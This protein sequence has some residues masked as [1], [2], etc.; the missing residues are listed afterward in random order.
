MKFDPAELAELLS[1]GEIRVP[2]DRD[3]QFEL[4]VQT[5]VASL[6]VE[7]AGDAVDA[8]VR[9]QLHNIQR[10]VRGLGVALG[11]DDRALVLEAV[12]CFSLEVEA[13]EAEGRG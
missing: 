5:I 3:E 11:H 1:A 13:A 12:R 7:L 10:A 4:I 6:A 8:G 9:A 2:P